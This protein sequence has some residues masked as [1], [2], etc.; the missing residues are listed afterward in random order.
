MPFIASSITLSL[1]GWG[2]RGVFRGEQLTYTLPFSGPYSP[3]FQ[4][5]ILS[6]VFVFL[7]AFLWWAV[8]I[9]TPE[10]MKKEGRAG[11]FDIST[12][13]TLSAVLGVFLAG[14][15]F[16][17]LLFFELMTISSYFWVIHR[18]NEEAIRAGY[19]Y[20]F[21]SIFGGLLLALGIVFITTATN[22]LPALGRGFHPSR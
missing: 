9:Y 5:D 7:A 2:L 3:T 4:A 19:F 6:C 15:L 10:Y 22:G 12:L 17:M 8:S 18:R 14:D 1:A 21:F 13:L 11:S 20:L 16:T